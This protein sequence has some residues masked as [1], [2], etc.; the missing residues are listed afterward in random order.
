MV[1]ISSNSGEAPH[2]SH[3]DVA[4]SS[5]SLLLLLVV[6]QQFQW[7]DVNV[8]VNY[9]Q[10]NFSRSQKVWLQ[11]RL[12]WTFPDCSDGK[13]STCNVG[14]SGF[15]PWVGKIPWRRKW[16]PTP[17]LLPRKFH[18][19][20]SLVGYS[21]WGSKKQDTTEQLHFHFSLSLRMDLSLLRALTIHSL[22]WLLK[23]CPVDPTSNSVSVQ[24]T[25]KTKSIFFFSSD[26]NLIYFHL[27]KL[28]SG[29]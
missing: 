28:L 9:V 4:L 6:G 17:V 5:S 11:D 26:V 8:G 16:Q 29:T 20:R 7:L 12:G 19:W 1:V 24:F 22:S 14:D 13:A 15:E 2:N 27:L 3:V 10:S 25:I 23:N 18:G 21:P